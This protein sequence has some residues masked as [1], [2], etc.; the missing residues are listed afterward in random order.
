MH[1]NHRPVLNLAERGFVGTVL[2]VSLRSRLR[3]VMALRRLWNKAR[4][5]KKLPWPIGAFQ[6]LWNTAGWGGVID[7]GK[8]GE[9]LPL[10]PF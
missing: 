5:R 2:R 9:H 7:V 4:H 10:A 8:P 1:R 6:R 3:C